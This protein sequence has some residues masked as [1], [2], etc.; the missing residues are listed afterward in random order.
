MSLL[1]AGST[2]AAGAGGGLFRPIEHAERALYK[3]LV[4]EDFDTIV[5]AVV[6]KAI[7]RSEAPLESPPLS[8]LRSPVPFRVTPV[9]FAETEENWQSLFALLKSI[10]Y[11]NTHKPIPRNLKKRVREEIITILSSG[12]N[13]QEN[14][15]LLWLLS[16]TI[17]TD[18]LD[19]FVFVLNKIK[20]KYP[21]L[22]EYLISWDPII[23]PK[24]IANILK[25]FE[26]EYN[27]QEN[28]LSCKSANEIPALIKTYLE[29][30]DETP[31]VKGFITYNPNPEDPHVVPI[32]IKKD[33][34]KVKIFVINSLGHEITTS[35]R[36]MPL[37]LRRLFEKFS[38]RSEYFDKLEIYSYKPVRQ[39]DGSSCSI[40]SVLDLKNLYESHLDGFDI[41]KHFLE[42]E[43]RSNKRFITNLFMDDIEVGNCLNLFEVD[44]LPPSM[45]KV[46]QSFR[47]LNLYRVASPAFSIHM[48]A[49]LRIDARGEKRRVIQSIQTLNKAVDDS[50]KMNRLSQKINKYVE[51]KRLELIVIMLSRILKDHLFEA[52][53]F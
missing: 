45:M 40:F 9:N 10:S 37:V 28:I 24:G 48:P 46:T 21:K 15:F 11:G 13:L 6:E 3:F 35:K 41:F 31:F 4:R 25:F 49:F 5:R 33:E 22:N 8:G 51:R 32:F 47:K 7:Y 14:L 1:V 30:E 2:R 27:F 52:L 26:D 44:R 53:V 17:S 34:G 16:Q 50:T 39:N 18:T 23:T 12:V 42:K 20:T 19:H 38:H 43:D 29:A 36:E